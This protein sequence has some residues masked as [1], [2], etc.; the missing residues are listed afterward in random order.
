MKRLAAGTGFTGVGLLSAVAF[1]LSRSDDLGFESNVLIL[2]LFGIALLVL[3]GSGYA[4]TQH[5]DSSSAEGRRC[6]SANAPSGA[7]R[8]RTT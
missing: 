3:G 4:A 1:V 8:K 7:S 2:F 6:D 5:Q